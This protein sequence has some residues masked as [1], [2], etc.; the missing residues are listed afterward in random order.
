[1][2]AIVLLAANGCG[3]RQ[4]T[5]F[6]KQ[7]SMGQWESI[8]AQSIDCRQPSDTCSRLHLIRGEACLNL[9]DRGIRPLANYACA[10]DELDTGLTM[11]GDQPLNDRLRY[12]EMICE[13]LIGVHRL[14]TSQPV[15]RLMTAAKTLHR[16]TPASVPAH[17]YLSMSRLIQA[18]RMVSDHGT[19][20]RM[21]ACIRLKR[22][23]TDVL[24]TIQAAEAQPP[25]QWNRFADRYQRLAFELGR[26]LGALECQ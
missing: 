6:K 8:A 4:L 10:T 24:S 14:D 12:Q 25:P 18:R 22:T 16:L 5:R 19:A 15:D 9:G 2:A 26:T 20:H 23:T 1:M 17:Y 7:A 3:H 13:A 11:L 21:A